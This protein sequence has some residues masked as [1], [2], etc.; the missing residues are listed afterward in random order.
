V[1]EKVQLYLS[2]ILFHIN[3]IN[4]KLFNI[5]SFSIYTSKQ[6]EDNR[7]VIE[8]CLITIGE[9]VN[10][11]KKVELNNLLNNTKEIIGFKNLIVYAY[12]RI[13]DAIV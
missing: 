8:R 2:Q 10:S 9:A 13:D 1:N 3:K 4:E 7:L 12:D 11:I 6:N 5:D